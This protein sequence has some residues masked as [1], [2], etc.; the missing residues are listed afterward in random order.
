MAIAMQSV[1][2]CMIFKHTRTCLQI[3][4]DSGC[5]K[6][7]MGSSDKWS[8]DKYVKVDHDGK[9][10]VV[11]CCMYINQCRPDEFLDSIFSRPLNQIWRLLA[12]RATDHLLDL[13]LFF[14]EMQ[15]FYLKHDLCK[16][17]WIDVFSLAGIASILL[18][19][20]MAA[21]FILRAKQAAGM[22]GI[23]HHTSVNLFG[24]NLLLPVLSWY[25]PLWFNS[26]FSRLRASACDKLSH[27]YSCFYLH[28]GHELPGDLHSGHENPEIYTDWAVERLKLFSPLIFPR[29]RAKS[30]AWF[31]HLGKWL[32]ELTADRKVR[33]MR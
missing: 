14:F 3:L 7:D 26:F 19:A 17:T 32:Q 30:Q 11:A 9:M 10:N 16:H 6:H 28:S 8:S 18:V 23:S 15:S 5:S 27:Q 1:Y 31:R 4:A 25:A 33:C 2:I 22:D 20:A 29:T 24:E 12:V 21:K 13:S